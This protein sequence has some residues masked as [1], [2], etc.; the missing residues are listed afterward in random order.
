MKKT[1]GFLNAKLQL[2]LVVYVIIASFILGMFTQQ[3]IASKSTPKPAE[4]SQEKVIDLEALQQQVLPKAGFVFKIKWGDLGKRLIDDGVIDKKKLAKALTG[5][6]NMPEQLEKYLDS[7]NQ[8]QI[9]LNEGNA[10]F[11]VDVLWGLGLAQKSDILEKGQMMASG[12]ASKFASTGGY[13]IGVKEPMQIYAKFS[14]IKLSPDQE[15]LVKE[16]AEGVFRPCCGNSTAFP[17]CNHGMA[18]LGLIELMVSQN[19]SKEEIY[20]TV[21]AFNSYWFPQT[22]LD[23]AY[24]FAKNGKDFKKVSAEELLSKTFS[25]SMGYQAIKRQIPQVDWPALKGGKGCGA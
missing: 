12:D 22:Y 4:K 15:V 8:D 21:L 19:F 3:L 25:S 23:L 17:D 14:Y 11:W 16:I 2:G 1:K 10:Q 20:K 13:T 5:G 24:H 18:A 9:E 7:S 6:E